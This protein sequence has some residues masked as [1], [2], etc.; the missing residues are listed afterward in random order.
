M[1]KSL[2]VALCLI[3]LVI[4]RAQNLVLTLDL[5][6]NVNGTYS[7]SINPQ[8]IKQILLANIV[9]PT[10]K[11][12]YSISEQVQHT[13]QAPLQIPSGGGGAAAVAPAGACQSLDAAVTALTSETDESKVP[14]DVAALQ[15]EIGKADAATCAANIDLANKAIAATSQ[16]RALTNRSRWVTATCLKLPCP[17]AT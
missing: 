6:K 1:K 14:Q 11:I 12:T 9:S 7:Q 3:N 5:S 15:T 2:I 13:P 16:L 17:G 4:C 8:Q 10:P